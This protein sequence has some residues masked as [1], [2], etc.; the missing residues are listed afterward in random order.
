MQ[1]G[2]KSQTDP[3]PDTR[4]ISSMSAEKEKQLEQIL[5]LKGK[6]NI[7]ITMVFKVLQTVL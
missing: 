5:I 1:S 3:Q 2:T 4:K 7:I 6:Q